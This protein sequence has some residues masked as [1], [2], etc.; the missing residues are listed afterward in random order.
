MTLRLFIFTTLAAILFLCMS[1]GTDNAAAMEDKTM[2]S[3]HI[4]ESVIAGSWYSGNASHLQREVQEYVSQASAVDFKGQLIALISPHAG[5][6]YSGQV[7][8]YAYKL[9]SERKFSSVVVIAPSHRSYFRGVSVYDRGGYRT[10]LG[11]VPLDRELISAMKQRESRIE[12]VPEAHSQEHSLEIQLP[13]LQVLMPDAKLVPLVMGNQDFATC[14]WL[15]EAVA[16]CI[17]NRSVLVVASSD[18]SHFHPYK[19]AKRLD[20]VVLDKVNDF[21]PQGLSDDLANGL[22]EAC[23]GGPM[24]TA[25]LIARRLGANK[26]RVLHYANSGD[27]TGDHSGVVGYMAAALWSDSKKSQGKE[28]KNKRVG[29]DLGLTSEEKAQ[30]LAIARD[31]VES[32]CRGEKTGE[33][34]VNSPTLQE[35]R[36]AFVTLHKEGKLRGCIGHI[37]AKGPLVKTIVEMAEAA[38]FHDPRFS[39]VSSKELGLLEYEISVLTPL[40][41]IKDVDEIEVGRHGIYI[42]RGSCSGL[43]L[44]QVATEWGWDR[45]TFLEHTCTKAGLPEDAWKDKKTEIYIFSADV[46][47]PDDL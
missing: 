1:V 34:V 3:E 23:G 41:L 30:L 40:Q 11:V 22:C 17:E 33:F 8:A 36:G 18:L 4:R 24:V 31:V 9:L 39:P 42:K 7:A 38:A 10:P 46:F 28:S 25:M 20:Q 32:H 5:Y 19:Q 35:P 27:V 6:R 16:D 47:S 2:P 45:T 14:E 15:A 13:F 29:V 37:R 44:P 26:S 12:Y 43:L 21:D